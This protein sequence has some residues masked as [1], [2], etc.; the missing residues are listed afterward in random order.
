VGVNKRLV[1]GNLYSPFRRTCFSGE[2]RD[3]GDSDEL[4]EERPAEHALVLQL[5]VAALELGH[6]VAEALMS[7]APDGTGSRSKHAN[8]S[9]HRSGIH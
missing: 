7:G 8:R 4:S 5:L 9:F 1:F 2:C 6:V 3:D